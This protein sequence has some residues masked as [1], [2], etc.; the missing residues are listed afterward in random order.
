MIRSNA[1]GHQCDYIDSARNGK[2][3]PGDALRVDS[4]CI[5]SGCTGATDIAS[6]GCGAA[7]SAWFPYQTL[8]SH[9]TWWLIGRIVCGINASAN[10]TRTKGG[11]VEY[12]IR[13]HHA[14]AL[15]K[16]HDP[17]GCGPQ[18]RHR[19]G[20]PNRAT[21]LETGAVTWKH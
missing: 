18:C 1:C 4:R 19:G 10:D 5:C 17:Y 3:G 21:W 12:L 9:T 8:F 20:C 11:V 7:T 2:F 13:I 14:P 6:D 15:D 16:R